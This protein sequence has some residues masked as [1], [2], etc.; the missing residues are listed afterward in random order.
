MIPFEQAQAIVFAQVHRTGVEDVDLAAA[1]GRVLALDVASDLDFPPF[2]K[3]SMDGFACRAADLG[4]TLKVV[5][6]LP[7]GKMPTRAIGPGECA[8]IMTGARV[9]VGADT[10]FMVEQSEATAD[11]SVRFTGTKTRPNLCR[12]AE[13]VRAG[14]V[15]LPAGTLLDPRHVAV[16]ASVGV[17]RPRVAMRPRVAILATGD[18]LVEPS[19]V[20]GPSQIRNSNGWQLAAQVAA[21]GGVPTYYGI[22]R[23]TVDDLAR[24]FRLAAA[25]S[26]VVLL[27]GGVS[28]GDFDKVPDMLADEGVRLLF[29]AVAMKPGKPTTFGIRDDLAVFGLPGNPVSTYVVFEVLVRP[30]LLAMMG[31]AWRPVWTVAPLAR[32]VRRRSLDRDEW[33]PVVIGADGTAEAVDYHGSADFVALSRADGLTRVPA[34]TSFLAAGTSIRVQRLPS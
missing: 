29:D 28:A 16:L 26:D 11:D 14:D 33:I 20:P 3:S 10:V 34:G 31:H 15:V 17:A 30:F 6:T 18:E 8:R 13:D 2:D 7:A 1:A 32:D 23:D 19:E 4:Q 5:E 22:A 12:Q 25:S 9:P 21:A 27:S 24:L